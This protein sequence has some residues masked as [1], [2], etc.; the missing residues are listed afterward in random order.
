MGSLARFPRVLRF[1]FLLA[2]LPFCLLSAPCTS[3]TSSTPP[4]EKV[5]VA[6][7]ANL[8]GALL[9]VAQGKGY[10]G[11][12]GL[13]VVLNAHPYGKV[14][15]DNMVSGGADFAVSAETPVVFTI[16]KG[17]DMMVVASVLESVK[18]LS[19]VAMLQYPTV[20]ALAR[21]LSGGEKDTTALAAIRERARRQRGAFAQRPGTTT[22]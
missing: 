13:D 10:F 16:L 6:L 11:E 1:A 17:D 3:K 18:D 15:L 2:L 14:A 8:Y 22:K 7:P 5:T 21:H 20:R 9:Y 4:V 12:E 19:I